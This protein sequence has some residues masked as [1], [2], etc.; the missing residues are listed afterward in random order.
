[1]RDLGFEVVLGTR[2]KEIPLDVDFYFIWWWQWGFMPMLKSM[3][4]HKPCIITGVFDYRW[5][6]ILA[7]LRE[8]I[9]GLSEEVGVNAEPRGGNCANLLSRLRR[10]SGV[11]DDWGGVR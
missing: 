3:F 5:N 4:R 1:M 2:W 10:Q 11:Q 8:F 6:S 9:V 7:H